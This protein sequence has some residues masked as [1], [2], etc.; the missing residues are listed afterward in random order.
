MYVYMYVCMY[1]CMHVCI[2]DCM[3]GHVYIY[4]YTC[5]HI[6]IHIYIYI[7]IFWEDEASQYGL[8]GLQCGRAWPSLALP[9]ASSFFNRDKEAKLL[10]KQQ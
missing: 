3:Y 7:C 4:M 6:Y 5:I 8:D 2:Y 9:L 1:A 10:V